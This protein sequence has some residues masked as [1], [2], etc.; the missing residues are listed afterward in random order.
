MVKDT[1]RSKR[2]VNC[3]VH[4]ISE[5]SVLRIVTLC[6]TNVSQIGKD[7]SSFCNLHFSFSVWTFPVL[8]R[9]VFYILYYD[10]MPCPL[11]SSF[12]SSKYKGCECAGA[13]CKLLVRQWKFLKW[14]EIWD[15]NQLQ[16]CYWK[17]LNWIHID[18]LMMMIPV[19]SLF[20]SYYTLKESDHKKIHC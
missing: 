7:L 20:I 12:Q 19:N 17:N 4:V 1:K 10:D 5:E 15:G 9:T 8:F 6:F 16:H 13:S 3:K 2:G 11:G 14:L 18:E